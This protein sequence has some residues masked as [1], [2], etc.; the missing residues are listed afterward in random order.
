MTEPTNSTDSLDPQQIDAATKKT[1]ESIGSNIRNLRRG[2]GQ[3][4]QE[5]STRTELS[6]S[7]LSLVE[8]GKSSPSIGALVVIADALKVPV[9][10]L[11]IVKQA[12]E[13]QFIVGVN[14]QRSFQVGEI[15]VRLLR[16]DRTRGVFISINEYKPHMSKPAVT[17]KHDGYEYAYVLEGSPCLELDGQSHQLTAGDLVF[18]DSKKAHR[19]WNNE[20]SPARIL[21]F[22]LQEG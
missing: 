14:G 5:L 19:I 2:L 11:L 20:S 17:V 15:L 1:M 12:G 4:L 7:M 8:R 22:N 16:E 10:D 18:F 13:E 3:T 21:W 6:V 9:S